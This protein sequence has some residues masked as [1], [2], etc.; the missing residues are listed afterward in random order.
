MTTISSN[1]EVLND[2]LASTQSAATKVDDSSSIWG[3]FNTFLQILTTQLQNQDPTEP[4]DAS[5]FTNQ[6]VQYAEVEQQISTNDK[7]SDITKILNSNGITP[8]LDYI[9]QYVETSTTDEMVVQGGVGMMSYVLNGEA[10]SAEISVQD[11]NGDVIAT[12]D[13]P[14]ELGMNRIAWDGGLDEGGVAQDGVYKF[15]IT[16]KDGAGDTMEVSD[17]RIIGQV[18]SIETDEDGKLSLKIGDL[19]IADSDILSVFAAIAT[20][21]DSTEDTSE[22]DTTEDD[23][24][25]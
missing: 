1:S 24:T 11:E 22:G 16:A 9:G 5:E 20:S 18:S 23:T 8:V 10:L 4:V 15:V 19:S 21:P 17:I 6:L 7:L 25:T 13:G 3:E 14:S 12:I 2:Y